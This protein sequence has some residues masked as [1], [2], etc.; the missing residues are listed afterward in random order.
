M[1]RSILFSGALLA[2]GSSA[3]LA[4]EVAIS[5]KDFLSGAGDAKI[6]EL[7]RQAAASGKTL[8]IT[9]PPYWQDKATAK[10]HSGAANAAVRTSDAFF[11]N[12]LVRIE[13]TTP[14]G[15]VGEAP[16]A[17]APRPEARPEPKPA[18]P[19]PK[20]VVRAPPAPAPKPAPVEAPPPTPA[21]MCAKARGPG[22]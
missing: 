19:A 14:A 2:A 4:Q 12:V 22:K 17:A 1:F 11:E 21:R 9:A 8:V 7:A 18:P 10:A 3:A 15:K 20:P 16:K 13:V 6:A 5:G